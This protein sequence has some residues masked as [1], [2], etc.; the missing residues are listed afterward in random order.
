MKRD[1]KN[2]NRSTW[3]SHTYTHSF[4]QFFS[5]TVVFVWVL[6]IEI[7]AWVCVCTSDND[8]FQFQRCVCVCVSQS[9]VGVVCEYTFVCLHVFV[10][11]VP[12]LKLLLFF[13]FRNNENTCK[14][15]SVF[16]ISRFVSFRLSRIC[17]SKFR[18]G[19]CVQISRDCNFSWC[20]IIAIASRLIYSKTENIIHFFLLDD[21]NWNFFELLLLLLLVWQIWICASNN[22]NRYY[23][24]FMFTLLH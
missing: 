5:A 23:N 7:Y 24:L 22:C 10:R 12:V 8:R 13:F 6:T 11:F 1:L 18:V 4:T 2:N 17:R 21:W 3:I 20:F 9:R 15:W 14:I 16:I 19:M